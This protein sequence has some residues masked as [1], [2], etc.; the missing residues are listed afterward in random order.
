[1]AI[2]KEQ[3]KISNCTITTIYNKYKATKT[4]T[5]ATAATAETNIFW[6]KKL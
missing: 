2:K 6:T 1:M 3:K 5:T 4:S